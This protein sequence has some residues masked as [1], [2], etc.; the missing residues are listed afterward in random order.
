MRIHIAS[1][2]IKSCEKYSTWFRPIMFQ[3]SEWV[4]GHDGLVC[5]PS[6]TM[7]HSTNN[8]NRVDIMQ[9]LRPPDTTR[10]ALLG[11]HLNY[12]TGTSFEFEG[13][14]KSEDSVKRL[15]KDMIK[16]EQD[17]SQDLVIRDSNIKK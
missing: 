3:S 11:H 5:I 15:V 17:A 7:Q 10:I 6:S 8:L 14:D 1:E 13:Y 4:T 16:S 2:V 9:L 12:P